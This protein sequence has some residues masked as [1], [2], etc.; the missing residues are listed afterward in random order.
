MCGLNMVIFTRTPYNF[1][2]DTNHQREFLSSRRHHGV[3]EQPENTSGIRQRQP[4][5]QWSVPGDVGWRSFPLC[6]VRCFSV[7]KI[8]R[9]C[10]NYKELNSSVIKDIVKLKV[11]LICLCSRQCFQTET[12]FTEGKEE[13]WT[14]LKA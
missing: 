13:L 1:A 3:K 6:T 9:L 5:S 2:N 12:L 4:E 7:I 14:I 10:D 8:F 11:S